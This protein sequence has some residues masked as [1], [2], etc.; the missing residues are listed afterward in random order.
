M[1]FWGEPGA[2]GAA[3]GLVASLLLG[4]CGYHL[5]GKADLMPKDVHTIAILPFTNTTVR[6]KL[7]DALPEAISREF[8]TRTHYKVVSDPTQADAVLHGAVVNYAA[9][10]SIIDQ[11]TGRTSGV[12]IVLILDVNLTDRTTGKVIF[13]RPRYEAHERYE[14]ATTNDTQYFDESGPALR[15]MSV[16]VARDLVTSIL[17]NF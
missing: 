11:S 6:Y 7:A 10:P 13:S 3:I 16:D 4:G 5:A 1:K 15:R 9:Y 2:F 14:L 8:I 17:D 12:Q